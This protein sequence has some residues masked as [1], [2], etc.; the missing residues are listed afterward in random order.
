MIYTLTLN[1]S[2]DY[3]VHVTQLKTGDVNRMTE[4]F[5]LPGGKGINVSRIL[6]R[7]GSSS[8]ALG[9]LGG[10]TGDF[11]EKWLI[12]EG[13]HSQFTKVKQDTRINV[14][15][16][17]EE[18]TEI[19]GLGPDI[20]EDEIKRLK[21]T[22]SELVKA[23]DIVVL[24]GST[25]G[26]LRKGFYQELIQIIKENEAEFVI[27]TTGDDLLAALPE[28]PLL[29]KPNNHELAELYKTS[30]NSLD[31]IIIYG[32]K[33]LADGAKNVIISMAGDGA[34][35]ITEDGTYLSNVLKH[36]VK[37]SVGAGDS[38]IAGFLGEFSQSKDPLEAFKWGVACGSATTFSDDLATGNFIR[39]LLPEVTAK[40]L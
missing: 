32:K 13:I 40:K 5:K 1:P 20:T 26:S 8:Y 23:G 4:D 25:P 11:I 21:F 36:E 39:K 34:L 17:A 6:Q 16:K 2:I 27:D 33:L 38:M 15:L 29:V 37:N 30:L 12:E 7:I 24:S 19:N 35:L 10:F 28:K 22:L 3:I 9:F 14:K 18:E 31:D